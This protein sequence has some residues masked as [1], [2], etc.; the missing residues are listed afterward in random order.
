MLAG[1]SI[2]LYWGLK[3]EQSSVE[4]GKSP[5]VTHRAFGERAEVLRRNKRGEKHCNDNR[6]GEHDRAA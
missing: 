4:R 2:S 6:E 3:A 5:R 1:F